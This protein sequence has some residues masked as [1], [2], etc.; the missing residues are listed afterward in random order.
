MPHL[1]HTALHP[2]CA[3]TTTRPSDIGLQQQGVPELVAAALASVHPALAPLLAGRVVVTGGCAALPGFCD[4][5]AREARALVPQEYDLQV[6]QPQ[7]GG[8]CWSG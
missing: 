6:V 2:L 3:A 1:K 7:V 4:R 8:W 5:L